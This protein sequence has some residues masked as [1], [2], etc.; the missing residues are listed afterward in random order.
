MLR[1]CAERSILNIG[2]KIWN[3]FYTMCAYVK[4]FEIWP[5]IRH[6]YI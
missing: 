5:T 4:K 3:N 6:G 2:D 1:N